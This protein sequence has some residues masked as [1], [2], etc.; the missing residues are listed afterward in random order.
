MTF[1]YPERGLTRFVLLFGVLTLRL[2]Y[3]G[4]SPMV[5]NIRETPVH[6]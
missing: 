5:V 2:F 3:P 6:K 1:L 4:L